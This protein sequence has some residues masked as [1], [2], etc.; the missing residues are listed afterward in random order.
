MALNS[1]RSQIIT[2]DSLSKSGKNHTAGGRKL[3][4]R[5]KMAIISINYQLQRIKLNM[6]RDSALRNPK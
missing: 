5:K 4:R 6:Q 3:Q 1:V 2:A